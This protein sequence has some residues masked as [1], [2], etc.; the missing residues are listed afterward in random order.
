M[1]FGRRHYPLQNSFLVAAVLL[2]L[3]F[4]AL[5]AGTKRTIRVDSPSI[6]RTLRVT[7]V[8]PEV[9]DTS[10]AN[11]PVVYLLHGYR[12]SGKVWLTLAPLRSLA[13]S[14]GLVFVAPSGSP[15]SWWLDSP[16]REDSRYET[17]IVHELLP[18]IENRYA[19]MLAPNERALIGSS[20]GGH[21][22]LTLLA[23]HP[24]RFSA[25]VSISGILDLQEFPNE[26]EIAAVLGPAASHANRWQAHSFV[27]LIDSLA[28]YRPYLV[29]DCGTEDFAL[30]GNRKAHAL[31][32]A[33][34]V[35][36]TYLERP[37]GHTRQYVDRYLEEHI[38]R[39]ARALRR[40]HE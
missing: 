5:Y 11:F 16:L 35:E 30:N 9:E 23:R 25:A 34:G 17:F 38:G 15:G 29:L 33:A 13:D 20:M 14:H 32:E 10:E 2:G 36:H 37:G 24:D 19:D 1:R 40:P 21:G 12:S 6:G 3:C 39:V 27:G 28:P 31:L 26:W 7:V 18:E 8:L 22:A 4:S